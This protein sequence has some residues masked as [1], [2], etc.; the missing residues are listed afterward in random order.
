MRS[1][2]F[3]SYSHKDTT[4]L[5]RLHVH[6]APLVRAKKLEVWDDTQIQPG[7]AREDEIKRA[8]AAA[9]VGVLLVSADYIASDFIAENELPPLLAAVRDDGAVLLCVILKPSSFSEMAELA[10]L[11]TI[12]DPLTP[13]I[14]MSEGR[15]EDVFVRLTWRIES[16]LRAPARPAPPPDGARVEPAGAKD[17]HAY[18]DMFDIYMNKLRTILR[19]AYVLILFVSAI[20]LALILSALLPDVE[21]VGMIKIMRLSTGLLC[22]GLSVFTTSG[23]VKK[24]GVLAFFETTK[25][26]LELGCPDDVR[27]RY[28]AHALDVMK[29]GLSA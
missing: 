17:P 23:V 26:T 27:E 4:W 21:K 16:A 25:R 29:R 18:A 7:A 11:Q 12:N 22:F 10:R 20:G 19:A 28:V 2:V 9:K 13:L 14:E 6:V 1:K 3:V 15:Q 24:V 8:I 5:D